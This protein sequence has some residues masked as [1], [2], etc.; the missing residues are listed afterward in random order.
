MGTLVFILSIL[1]A[2]LLVL[3]ILIQN[4]K[5]GG[6]DSTFG[7]ANQLGSVQKTNDVV[8]KATWYLAGIIV[9]LAISSATLISRNVNSA[10]PVEENKGKF[11][12]TY[13]MTQSQ[14]LPTAMPTEE[15]NAGNVPQ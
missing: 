7:A 1:A 3:V 14:P 8:E 11:D 13:N 10:A 6:I 5:G 9:V 2:V 4:P 12:P 15:G